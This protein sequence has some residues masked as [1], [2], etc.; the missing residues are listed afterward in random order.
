VTIIDAK[1]NV[2]F[3]DLHPGR[4]LEEK[5]AL[6]DPLLIE[7]GKTPPARKVAEPQKT[8]AAD[9]SKATAPTP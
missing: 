8:A 1:G 3:N 6:I 2:R 4:P 5:T 9:S 7:Q